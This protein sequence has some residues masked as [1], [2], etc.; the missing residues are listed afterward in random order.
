[1]ITDLH[2]IM[3]LM[4]KVIR[5]LE[6]FQQLNYSEDFLTQRFIKESKEV[7]ENVEELKSALWKYEKDKRRNNG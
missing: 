2:N 7:V 4:N 1:M 6:R 5:F 3:P